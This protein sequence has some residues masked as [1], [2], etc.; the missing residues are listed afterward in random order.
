[1]QSLIPATP[2]LANVARILSIL[3]L[4]FYLSANRHSWQLKFSA[5][6]IGCNCIAMHLQLILMLEAA[7]VTYSM[8]PSLS[9]G[10]ILRFSDLVSTF[11]I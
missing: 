8:L 1:M 2:F 7:I 4:F 6:F 11:F 10:Q 9:F 3:K 5:I